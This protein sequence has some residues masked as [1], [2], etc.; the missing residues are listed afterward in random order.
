MKISQLIETI[1]SQY[2][3][4]PDRRRPIFAQGVPGVGKSDA[5]RQAAHELGIG[6]MDLQATIEDPITLSGLPARAMSTTIGLHSVLEDH[7][8][9]LPFRD[10]LPTAGEGILC[11]DEINT[12]PPAVQAGLY[13]LFLHGKLGSYRLPPGWAVGATG[14]RD[15]DRA[16]TQRI[17]MPL[18]GRWTRVLVEVS[19]DD[20][21]KWALVHDI[22]TEMIAFFQWK[23]ELFHTFDPGKQEPY[24][25]PR[26]AV[27]ASHLIDSAP[28]GLEHELLCGTVGEG[29]AT[30]LVAFMRTY[31]QM[32]S[33]DAIL[34]DPSGAPVP[35]EPAAACAISAAL[36]HKATDGN[37]HR[38]LTYAARMM[39]EYEILIIKLA[40]H[41]DVT[42]CMTRAFI[43]WSS[44]NSEIV[45]S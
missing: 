24:C 27:F 41:R 1:K 14:N 11:I 25:C 39:K 21:T 32:V 37:F 29:V 12:A 13:D 3:Q 16:A 10:K 42:L 30:E 17:P 23:P 20:W 7:A 22:R 44:K 31:R 2:Q 35:D 6:F 38:V 28:H 4:P 40:T 18:M 45:L 26:T 19:I 36:A 43:E 15:E 5:F 34:L 33:P 9:F 8:V